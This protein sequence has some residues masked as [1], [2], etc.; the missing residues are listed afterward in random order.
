VAGEHRVEVA[1]AVDVAQG[2]SVA[3]VRAGTD[4]CTAETKVSCEV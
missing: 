1:V 3:A 4:T 2:H